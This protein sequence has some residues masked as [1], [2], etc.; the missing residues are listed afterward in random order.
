MF[1]RKVYNKLLEWKNKYSE[2][3][4]V[5]LEGARRVGKSTIA[6]EFAK[7]E[8]KSYILIDFA[9]T[10]KEVLEIFEDISNLDIFFL[11]L[12]TLTNTKLYIHES[13]IIFDEVQLFP[14][15]R[16]AIKYLVKDGRYN[17]IETGSLISIKKNV[18]NI[19][20]PS[21]EYKINVY[22]LDFEEFLWATNLC[23]YDLINIINENGK[24]I[25][26]AVNRQ[27]MRNFRIYMAVGGMPQAVEAFLEHKTFEEIDFVK[28]EII[29]L[30]MDD[31]KKIDPTGRISQIYASIP[32]QLSANKKRYILSNAINKR[33]T[34]KDEELLQELIDSKTV[35]ICYNSTQPSLSL[36]QTKNLNSYKLY[37]SDIGLFTTLLFNDE[38]RTNEQIYQK[39]LSN[40]LDINLGYIYENAVAQL[41]KANNRELYYHTWKKENSTHH[42]EIDFLIIKNKKVVPIEVKS[43]IVNNFNSLHAFCK[44]Y[45][46]VV[47][48]RYVFSQKDLSNQEMIKMRPFY[49]S[50]II[51]K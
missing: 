35:L 24:A 43:G 14:I 3:Y 49:L 50:Q 11:R 12:Q 28:R 51:L 25:G 36:S 39:L 40:K 48:E 18:K 4:A 47:G 37:I 5:M 22:P 16:Q 29:S 2:K 33:I 8:Y 19:L 32:S 31:F 15:A 30:Y 23:D 38:S 46:S 6:E 44:K 17:F 13:V 34:N 45:S 26:D 10:S 7:N 9:N 27:L 41:I 42:Y 21:E 20:I 1:K